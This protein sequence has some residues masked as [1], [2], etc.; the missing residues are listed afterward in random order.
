MRYVP[1]LRS[2]RQACLVVPFTVVALRSMRMRHFLAVM[3]DALRGR[4]LRERPTLVLRRDVSGVTVRR[5]SSLPYQV[6]GDHLGD[7]AELRMS[8]RPDALTVVV[9]TPTT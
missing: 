5:T 9:P 4:G 1:S 7:A 6:D 2:V 3:A 8:Y